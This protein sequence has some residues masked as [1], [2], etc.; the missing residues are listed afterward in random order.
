MHVARV[1]GRTEPDLVAAATPCEAL[2]TFERRADTY[3]IA[4]ASQDDDHAAVVVD[5]LV[6]EEGEVLAIGGKPEVF[7]RRGTV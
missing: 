1:K 5:T 2:Q 6:G 4:R 7:D 3:S